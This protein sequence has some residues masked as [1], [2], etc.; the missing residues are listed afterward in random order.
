MPDIEF[1]GHR[2]EVAQMTYLHGTDI[3]QVSSCH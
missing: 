3:R 1:F 2:H